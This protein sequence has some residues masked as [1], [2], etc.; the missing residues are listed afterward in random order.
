M[1]IENVPKGEYFRK[2]F[3]AF[4]V[5]LDLGDGKLQTDLQVIIVCEKLHLAKVTQEKNTP[6]QNCKDLSIALF[7]SIHYIAYYQGHRYLWSFTRYYRLESNHKGSVALEACLLSICPN[8][9]MS[10][11]KY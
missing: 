2:S 6:L 7:N 9:R 8:Y 3:I 11:C 4:C 1:C 5:E 10:Y